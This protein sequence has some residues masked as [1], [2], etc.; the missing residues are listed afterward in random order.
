MQDINTMKEIPGYKGLYSADEEGRIYSLNY[1]GTGKIKALSKGLGTNGYHHVTLYKN[2][3]RKPKSVHRLILLTFA[4]ECPNDMEVCHLNGIR[5]DNRLEN[6]CYG[7]KSSNNKDITKH[8]KRKLTYDDVDEIKKLSLMKM[9]NT[10]IA[11]RFNISPSS[12]GR[13][14]NGKYYNRN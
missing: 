12:I 2:K 6:L 14:I 5:T 1:N 7:T 11:K 13:I 3:A 8:G 9:Q 4:R 10:K